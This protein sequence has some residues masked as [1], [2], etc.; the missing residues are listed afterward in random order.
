MY[1]STST[2]LQSELSY[3][4]DRLTSAAAGRRRRQRNPR[5]RREAGSDRTR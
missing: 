3:R 2:F 4:T 1:E 5:G